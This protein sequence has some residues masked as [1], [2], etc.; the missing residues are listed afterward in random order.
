M[1]RRNLESADMSEYPAKD[2]FR[3]STLSLL[4]VSNSHVESDRA[5]IIQGEKLSPL[6]LFTDKRNG[7]VENCPTAIIVYARFTHLMRTP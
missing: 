3:A 4:G 5:T 2:I 7:K 1:P 6:L